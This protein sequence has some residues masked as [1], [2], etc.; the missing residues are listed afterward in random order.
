MRISKAGSLWRAFGV[1]AV[2]LGSLA[3]LSQGA[4]AIPAEHTPASLVARAGEKD[5]ARWAPA[6]PLAVLRL[7]E[8]DRHT[9]QFRGYLNHIGFY[10]SPAYQL[11][12]TN[13]GLMQ[14]QIGLLGLAATAGMDGWTAAGH[15]LGQDA[16]LAVYPGSGAGA[17]PGLLIVAVARDAAARTK[18]IDG[19]A[20][21]LG[22]MKGGKAD[23][24]KSTV[25]GDHTI[26][27]LGDLRYCTDGDALLISGDAALISA[28]IAARAGGDSL[29]TSGELD[30]VEDAAPGG[31]MAL[32][33]MDVKKLVQ[34]AAADGKPTDGLIENPLGGFLFGGWVKSLV[35]ADSAIAWMSDLTDGLSITA[36][37]ENSKALPESYRG[38]LA[39]FGD[40][41]VDLGAVKLPNELMSIAVARDWASL[42]SD[43]ESILTLPGAT[44]AATFAATMT[45]LMGNFDF[46]ED[47]LPRVNGPV[48]FYMERQ[49]FSK[50]GYQPTPTLPAFAMVAPLKG[51]GEEMLKQ[52]LMSG[53]QMAISFINFDQAQKKQPGFLMGMAEHRGVS[54]LKASYPPPGTGGEGS[55]MKKDGAA[56]TGEKEPMQEQAAKGPAS[57]EVN[58]RYNFEPVVAIARD[59]YIVATSIP[60]M[61]ALI[62]AVLDAKPVAAGAKSISSDVMTITGDQVARILG[63]NREELV[64]QRM[65]EQD[66]DRAQAERTIDALLSLTGK[67]DVL[68]VVSTPG[69]QGHEATLTLGMKPVVMQGAGK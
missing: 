40:M 51:G 3:G 15:V 66:E 42:F 37:V 29:A 11:I 16:V 55:M 35:Q 13:P 38:F 27:T 45:T 23:P 26:Y 41:A 39:S 52:R 61:N 34:A 64:V 28:A 6:H 20:T 4:W 49:D 33:S 5:A 2:V 8:P 63:D 60:T 65:L 54:I 46:L 56:K 43:R 69:A 44:Q 57:G 67:V 14:A 18:F 21:A 50:A 7:V 25:V 32:A 58:V 47:F 12:A 62:D 59:H 24:Q 31:A 19:A 1:S 53:S 9:T 68:R 22:L 36:R 10:E 17:K 48:H 30:K